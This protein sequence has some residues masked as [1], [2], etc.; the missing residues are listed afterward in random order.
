MSAHG[1]TLQNVHFTRDFRNRFIS[2]L[3]ERISHAVICSPYF[4]RLPDPFKD[5]IGFC[6]FLSR[7][8]TD[9]IHVVTRPPGCDPQAISIETA[10]ILSTRGVDIYVKVS[11][12]LH[13]K[14]Y[15]FEYEIGFFRTF[16]G[17]ANFTLG[18]FQ[19]NH[20]VVTEVEGVGK[21]S[22]CH[23]E[24]ARL[25]ATGGTTTF[26]SW[27]AKGQPKGEGAAV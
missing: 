11:P 6:S 9:S 4:D 2:S 14:I 26:N 17:S 8:G 20:E 7:R 3:S 21:N 27:I 12:Y 24:I 10:K 15:H 5:I 22:P 18:G 13:A 23:R 1:V 19:R 16:I 25:Q